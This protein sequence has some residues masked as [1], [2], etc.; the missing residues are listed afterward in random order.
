MKILAGSLDLSK[1]DKT[2]IVEGKN[3]AKYYNVTILCYDKAD[4]YGN[5][6]AI[7]EGQS[8]EEREA[9]TP[10]KYLGNAKTVYNGDKGGETS[11][12]KIPPNEVDKKAKTSDTVP[13]GDKGGLPF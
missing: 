6:V 4:Q 12:S 10:K 9:E 8:K 7:T 3:G 1:I 5:D 11:K 2:R 13:D